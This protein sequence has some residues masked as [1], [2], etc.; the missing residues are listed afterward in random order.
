[1]RGEIKRK[2]NFLEIV[3]KGEDEVTRYFNNLEDDN[4]HFERLKIRLVYHFVYAIG[5]G[6]IQCVDICILF[7]LFWILEKAT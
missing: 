4:E 3:N 5:H 1:M 7:K 6:K 2:I